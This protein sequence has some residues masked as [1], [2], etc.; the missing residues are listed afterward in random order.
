MYQYRIR[1]GPGLVKTLKIG[2]L[3]LDYPTALAPLANL[4]D[5]A[6]RRLVDEI[7]GAG[8]LVTEMIS[9]EGINRRQPPTLAL[10]RTFDYRTPQFIQL[11]GSQPEPLVEAA[12][13]IENETNY[14]GID[15]NMGCPANK[16]IK[17]GAGSALLKDP[18][19][20]GKITAALKKSMTLPLTVKIRLG[21]DKVNV[22]EM[23]RILEAEGADAITV[24][25]RLRSQGYGGD[26]MWEYAPQLREQI[27]TV[28]IGNGDI[29]SANEARE[30]LSLVDG[31]MIGRDALA[32]PLIFAEIAGQP[33]G[34]GM[35]KMW[36]NAAILERL[37][38]LIEEHYEETMRLPR[39]KAFTRFLFWG[40]KYGKKARQKIYESKSFTE[41]RAIIAD[42]F[43][44]NFIHLK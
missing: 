20:A 10:M 44:G 43:E 27:K 34:Y 6:F 9:A 23:C 38:D 5:I 33:A 35:D 16:V 42:L 17:K 1:R 12:K 24:H 39:V 31:V 14:A 21:F 8:F 19:L 11:F 22:N 37:L 13:F 15:I 3:K 41:A 28:F 25:F 30:K 26:A 7:G 40:K 4:T 32:H 29:T 18:V 36:S 2:K